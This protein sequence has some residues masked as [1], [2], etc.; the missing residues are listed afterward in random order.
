MSPREMLGAYQDAIATPAPE[1]VLQ[2]AAVRVGTLPADL[3][4]RVPARRLASLEPPPPAGA[5][6]PALVI[7]RRVAL[8]A[9]TLAALVGTLLAFRRIG[10]HEIV[11]CAAQLEPRVGA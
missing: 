6:R 5:R 10:V 1:G 2:R 11:C 4:P 9:F 3:E 8:L 7:A